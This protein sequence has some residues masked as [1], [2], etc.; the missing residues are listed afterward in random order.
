MTFI[1]AFLVVVCTKII[2]D[3][4][5]R[6]AKKETHSVDC[7]SLEEFRVCFPKFISYLGVALFLMG[8][9]FAFLFIYQRDTNPVPFWIIIIVEFS[10][11][12][13]GLF[14]FLTRFDHFYEIRANNEEFTIYRFFRRKKTY[15][16]SQVSTY[17]FNSNQRDV[18][19][20]VQEKKI[21]EISSLMI[22]FDLFLERLNMENKEE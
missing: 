14:L 7:Q 17:K 16:F 21:V 18:R 12:I 1:R 4:I 22:G 5:E 19:V 13:P 2:L 8:A 15:H 11:I 10:I 20:Y 3:L 6:Q 9:F